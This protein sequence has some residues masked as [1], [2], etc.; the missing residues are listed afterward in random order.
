MKSLLSKLED[1]K[2]QLEKQ[3]QELEDE[4]RNT[5]RRVSEIQ[6]MVIG[7]VGELNATK[8]IIEEIKKEK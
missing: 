5:S 8:K 2:T 4:K 1:R 7:L 6:V 3:I